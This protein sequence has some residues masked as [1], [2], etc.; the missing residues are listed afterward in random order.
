MKV[1]FSQCQGSYKD[2]VGT[3]I[4]FIA[5]QMA[6]TQLFEFIELSELY[7]T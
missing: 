7:G 3:T 5:I 2:T 1:R 4:V 6:V